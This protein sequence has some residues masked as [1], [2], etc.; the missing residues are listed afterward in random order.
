LRYMDGATA[1]ASLPGTS[2]RH[3]EGAIII[4]TARGGR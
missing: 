3:I 2:G 4:E 1:S